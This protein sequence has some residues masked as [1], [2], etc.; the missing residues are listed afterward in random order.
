M[1]KAAKEKQMDRRMLLSQAITAL[2][3]LGNG[4]LTPT[5]QADETNRFDPEDWLRRRKL[6]RLQTVTPQSG[7]ELQPL[8]AQSRAEWEKEQR[9]YEKA[10]RE[11][12]G[13]WPDKRPALEARVFE[14]KNEPKWTRFK[15]G[16]RSFPSPA[17]YASE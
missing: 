4:W 12:I 7:K 9:L 17:P 13:G 1:N 3:V 6:G 10:L 15:V 14:Q 8:A 2:A 11:L 16:F 5:G